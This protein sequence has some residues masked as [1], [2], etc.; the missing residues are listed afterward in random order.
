RER[1]RVQGCDIAAEACR[2][3]VEQF[4][5]DVRRADFL[6]VPLKRGEVDGFCLWDTIEH[7][8][9]PDQYLAKMAEVLPPGGVVALTTGDIGSWLAR[10]QGERWRQ[11]HPPTHLWYF[12]EATLRRTLERFGFEVVWSAHIGMS[13]SLGQIVYSLTSLGKA[14]PSLLHRLC[15][16]S[17]LARL[18][19]P[20][21]TFD[22]MMVVARRSAEPSNTVRRSAA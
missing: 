2:V 10:K 9:A 17:G 15:V 13:R 20:L 16:G 14:R 1:W 6:D 8:D 3:A 4:G 12:S 11:I 21:N 5:L 19:L 22:L 7:L 18:S